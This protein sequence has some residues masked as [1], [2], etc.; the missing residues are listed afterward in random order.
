MSSDAAIDQIIHFL[1]FVTAISFYF[2]R[3]MPNALY[4]AL[5]KRST[6]QQPT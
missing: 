1:L 3:A 6:V 4:A 2:T 5:I